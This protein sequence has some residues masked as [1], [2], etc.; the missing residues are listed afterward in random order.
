MPGSLSI[1]AP[2]AYRCPIR[3]CAGTCDRSCLEVGFEQLD[4]ASVGSLAALVVEPVLSTGGVI[5]LPDGWLARAK[6]LCEARGMLLIADEAQTGFGRTGTMF[7]F[8]RE[9]VVP[10][11]VTVSKTLGGGV[12]L[13]A[14][15]TSAEV[16]ERAVAHGFLHITTHVS[17]PL[18]AAAG[19]AVL[20]V[21]EEERLV[22]RAREQGDKLMAGL[23]DLAGRHEA[24][25]D[26][27]GVGLLVGVELVE[28]RE[29]KVPA[30]DLG[31]AVTA[32]CLRR[33]LSMN[34]VKGEASQRNCLR[35]APPLT[36]S[37]DELELALEILDAALEAAMDARAAGAT[38]P[39]A[40]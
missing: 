38:A 16:E 27:R 36:V 40:S 9:G 17:D 34:I 39:P 8:E 29:S 31:A 1:P 20:D 12:P 32:E 24:I 2:Y 4:Q 7:A 33:G 11:I 28:D 25:G 21:L 15:V 10:D 35:I 13:G 22:E 37:D 19:L 18:P 30:N 23:R 26:V 3:H 5:P 14:T 6:E